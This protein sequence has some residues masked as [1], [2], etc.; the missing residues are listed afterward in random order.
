VFQLSPDGVIKQMGGDDVDRKPDMPRRDPAFATIVAHRTDVPLRH[1][2][3]H[4]QHPDGRIPGV[5][6]RVYNGCSCATPAG[7]R[8]GD[9]VAHTR[10]A[11][12]LPSAASSVR[13][14]QACRLSFRPDPRTRRR[15]AQT[16]SRLGLDD[17][18]HGG[19]LGADGMCGARIKTCGP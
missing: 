14:C 18:E 13:F 9:A 2:W 19:T 4:S 3:R 1:V 6:I 11:L 10:A 5:Q 17:G 7:V 12:E 8:G 15:R 16:R